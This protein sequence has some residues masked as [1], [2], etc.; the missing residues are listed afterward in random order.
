MQTLLRLLLC[1]VL[2]WTASCA[3]SEGENGDFD[4]RHTAIEIDQVEDVAW[5]DFDGDGDGDL[6]FVQGEPL[7]LRAFVNDQGSFNELPNAFPTPERLGPSPRLATG[8]LD[9]DG[10]DDL[11][12][13]FREASE[14]SCA[15]YLNE[16]DAEDRRKFVD[17]NDRF[18]NVN[19]SYAPLPRLVDYDRDRDADLLLFPM[20]RQAELTILRNDTDGASQQFTL[21]RPEGA[22]L[23]GQ[24]QHVAEIRAGLHPDLATAVHDLYVVNAGAPDQVLSLDDETMSYTDVTASLFASAL[25]EVAATVAIGDFDGD[26]RNDVALQHESFGLRLYLRAEDGTFDD[27]SNDLVG[28]P[29]MGF[30]SK[31]MVAEDFDRDG[32]LDLFI[33][34]NERNANLLL[35]QERETV[36]DQETSSGI[37]FSDRARAARVAEKQDIR[38]ART[39][40]RPEACDYAIDLVLAAVEQGQVSPVHLFADDSEARTNVVGDEGVAEATAEGG[41]AQGTEGPDVLVGHRVASTL[42]GGGGDD[43]LRAI[44]GMTVMSGGPGV[45]LFEARGVSII[46]MPEDEIAAGETIDCSRADFVLVDSP[47]SRTQLEAEGV[48]FRDCFPDGRCDDENRERGEDPDDLAD[49]HEQPTVLDVVSIGL[50]PGLHAI[51]VGRDLGF[52]SSSGSGFGNCRSNA[53]CYAIGL[54]VCLTGTGDPTLGSQ[55]GNCY[56]S[57]SA[58]HTGVVAEWCHDPFWA[59]YR[60][61]QIRSISEEE[62]RKLIMPVTFWLIRSEA[63]TDSGGCSTIPRPTPPSIVQWHRSV[64]DAMNV[65]TALF[66][67]W[68]IAFDHQFRVF[69]VPDDSPWVVDPEDDQCRIDLEP[70]HSEPNSV[71]KLVETYGLALFRP[72]EYNI[73]LS[74]LGGVS[75]SSTALV[76]NTWIKF[77]ILSGGAGAFAHEMGHG[78]GLPHPY[79]ANTSASGTEPDESESRDSWLAR[80]FPDTAYDRLQFCASDSQCNGIDAPSGT[81]RKAPGEQRGFCQNLKKD[82][83][84][85]GDHVCDTPWDSFPCF[86]HVGNNEGAECT[87]HDDCQEESSVRGRAYLTRCGGTGHC[88]KVRCS[89]NS[90]CDS[91]SWCADGTCIIWKEGT[92]SCCHLST[93]I[94]PGFDHNVCYERRPNGSVVRAPGVGPGSWPIHDNLM[95]YHRPH[96]RKRTVTDGQR[97]Q[98]VCETSYRTDLGPL[99]RKPRQLGD[100][101]QPCSL[102]PGDTTASYGHPGETMLISHGACASGVCQLVD[103]GINTLAYCAESSCDDRV[104]GVGEASLDCGGVCPNPCPT[105]RSTGPSSSHCSQHDDCESGLCEGGTCQPTCEDGFKNGSE[106]DVDS[107][108]ASF[109]ETCGTQFAGELCRYDEDCGPSAGCDEERTCILS[110]DCPINDD[111]TACADDDDCLGGGSCLILRRLCMYTTCF[112]DSQC[113]N[114]FCQ[115]PEGRCVCDSVADCATAS[116]IC[117]ITRSMCLGQCVDGRCLG[118][119]GSAIGF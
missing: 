36:Q 110:A 14:G 95:T 94:R 112:D 16:R 101:L 104:T 96:G 98:S 65:A 32:A 6:I 56:P 54:D 48:I 52:V 118:E 50:S 43:T 53:D 11:V 115:L 66:G 97:D 5:V 57:G 111:V 29:R 108:G 59:R 106:V 73:Y 25:P 1:L 58:G 30:T 93:D 18:A 51:D 85:D 9:R 86:R 81:C 114:S 17:A 63:A 44:A 10:D 15:F 61:E 90:D 70:G 47:L 60:F 28:V 117:E 33:A 24:V 49:C 26:G 76:G 99:L 80:P 83:A 19:V 13:C 62:G 116:D 4:V 75:W 87:I 67:R 37:R 71:G 107:G 119:C 91:G 23:L 88:V 69:E 41:C 39:F 21:F 84:E 45:D 92:D 20:D 89:Q 35:I 40:R 8:D 68:G 64:A 78:L 105:E 2:L 46:L 113:P 22:P 77:L 34:G 12:V 38:A 103:F 31:A 3:G 109:D 79:A 72:G 55:D 100:E 102:R 27:V 42:V 74:D 7:R 82:C